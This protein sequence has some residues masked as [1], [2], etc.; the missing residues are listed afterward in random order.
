MWSTELINMQPTE[1]KL[2][3]IEENFAQFSYLHIK[4]NLKGSS[5]ELKGI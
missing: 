3:L 4:T 5:I 2:L 1:I